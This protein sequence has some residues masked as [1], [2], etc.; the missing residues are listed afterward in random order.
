MNGAEEIERRL[1]FL[2]LIES[3]ASR[4]DNSYLFWTQTEEDHTKFVY[5]YPDTHPELAGL[6]AVSREEIGRAVGDPE[7]CFIFLDVYY[8]D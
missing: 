2:M 5:K 6:G 8:D 4:Y 7:N 3:C 1:N